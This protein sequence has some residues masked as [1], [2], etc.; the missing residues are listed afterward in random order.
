MVGIDYFERAGGFFSDHT[1]DRMGFWSFDFDLGLISSRHGTIR[2]SL[3]LRRARNDERP[4]LC[5]Y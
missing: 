1:K 3:G 2:R 4:V 5:A